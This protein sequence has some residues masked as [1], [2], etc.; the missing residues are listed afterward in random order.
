MKIPLSFLE[1]QIICL[2]VTFDSYHLKF[3]RFQLGYLEFGTN[4]K[5]MNCLLSKVVFKALEMQ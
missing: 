1:C 5:K 3:W 4:Q 2:L